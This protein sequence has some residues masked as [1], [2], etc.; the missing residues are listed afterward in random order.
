MLL[1][2]RMKHTNR[3]QM[4]HAVKAEEYIRNNQRLFQQTVQRC[5]L[6]YL[7]MPFLVDVHGLDGLHGRGVKKIQGQQRCNFSIILHYAGIF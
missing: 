2:K 7:T 4:R 6:R 5:Q 1:L 3:E